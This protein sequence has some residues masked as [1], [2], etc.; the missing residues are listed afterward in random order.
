[1]DM[2]NLFKHFFREFF[3]FFPNVSIFW[4]F[5]SCV[6]SVLTLSWPVCFTSAKES[7]CLKF[8]RF[9]ILWVCR[10]GCQAVVFISVFAFRCYTLVHKFRLLVSQ[11]NVSSLE[12]AL[13]LIFVQTCRAGRAGSRVSMAFEAVPERLQTLGGYV[14]WKPFCWAEACNCLSSPSLF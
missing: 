12:Q 9:L 5:L 10:R 6:V 3:L 7:F 14:F 13:K 4:F 1:M 11:M 8:E 2:A